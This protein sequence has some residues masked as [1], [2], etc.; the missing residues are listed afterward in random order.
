MVSDLSSW[1]GSLW[2]AAVKSLKFHLRRVIGAQKLTFEELSTLLSQ[3][4]S[5]LNSRPPC[6]LSEDTEDINFLTQLN[7]IASGPTLT[8]IKTERDE[9]THVSNTRARDAG[10]GLSTVSDI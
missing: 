9:R 7:F 1:H 2:E 4:E 3:L 5:C 6:A 8:I 10:A